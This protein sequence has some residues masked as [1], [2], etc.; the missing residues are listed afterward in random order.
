MINP[1]DQ[2]IVGPVTGE[3]ELERYVIGIAAPVE[4]VFEVIGGYRFLRQMLGLP[5]EA[6]G[7]GK[8]SASRMGYRFTF[9]DRDSMDKGDAISLNPLF[10]S[11]KIGFEVSKVQ[12]D[13]RVRLRYTDGPLEGKLTWTLEPDPKDDNRTIL[14]FTADCSIEDPWFRLVWLFF[15]QWVHYFVIGLMLLEIKRAAERQRA[16]EPALQPA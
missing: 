6:T 9:P 5:Q 16:G 4:D 12:K 11:L 14:E 2:F 8:V 7:S 15:F 3:L 10:E 13:H 1:L